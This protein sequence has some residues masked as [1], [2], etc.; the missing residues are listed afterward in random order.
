MSR[1]PI[2]YALLI[3]LL[4]SYSSAISPLE[5]L[6]TRD[7]PEVDLQEGFLSNREILDIATEEFEQAGAYNETF[8]G[9]FHWSPEKNWGGYPSGLVLVE[10]TYHMFM[11]ISPCCE[12]T[13][14]LSW[15][16]ATSSDL[17]TWKYEGDAISY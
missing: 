12:N 16:H 17:I 2:T 1:S 11:Q 14:F 5:G 4:V 10:K 7:T 6:F 8:R 13:T 9:Q 15:G 3:A